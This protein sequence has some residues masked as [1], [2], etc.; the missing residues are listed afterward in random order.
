MLTILACSLGPVALHN[1][2]DGSEVEVD[3]YFL[4][5]SA[6][7]QWMSEKMNVLTFGRPRSKRPDPIHRKNSRVRIR[8]RRCIV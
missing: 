8:P 1:D 6:D 7:G 4:F 3:G 2:V 5:P